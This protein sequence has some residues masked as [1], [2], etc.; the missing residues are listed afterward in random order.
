MCKFIQ[1]VKLCKFITQLYVANTFLYLFEGIYYAYLLF[2]Y[3]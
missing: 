3:F 2:F 1:C